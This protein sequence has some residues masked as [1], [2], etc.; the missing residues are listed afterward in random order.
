METFNHQLNTYLE[1]WMG[2]RGKL[3]YIVILV[4]E[5][6]LFVYQAAVFSA[7]AQSS[8]VNRKVMVAVDIGQVNIT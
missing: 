7:K 6:L 3:I 8:T 4:A 1:S 5:N 2:P